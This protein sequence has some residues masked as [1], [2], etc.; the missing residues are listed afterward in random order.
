MVLLVNYALQGHSESEKQWINMIDNILIQKM[1][2]ST[3]THDWCIYCRVT[4]DGKIQLML[5]Q[6]DNFLPACNL[7][8]RAKDIFKD[9]G[10]AIQF[11][12]KKENI[13]VPFKLLGVVKDCNGVD[14]NQTPHYIEMSCANYIQRLLKLQGW[15]TDSSK[16]LPPEM[17]P[18]SVSSPLNS[19][20]AVLNASENNNTPSVSDERFQKASGLKNFETRVVRKLDTY[21]DHSDDTYG[22]KNNQ[23][24]IDVF[25][26]RDSATRKQKMTYSASCSADE[27]RTQ[28]PKNSSSTMK[29]SHGDTK[30]S[31]ST[32]KLSCGNVEDLSSK[33]NT[34]I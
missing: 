22:P 21:A 30:D 31:S 6:V 18:S 3:T 7:E 34:S 25:S 26:L 13:I 32:M 23:N 16:P 29:L 19:S 11:D 24:E 27:I 4:S 5:R 33:I 15:D 10:T 12:V 9:I 1:R 28:D 20:S 14:I 2:F 17:V 8:M